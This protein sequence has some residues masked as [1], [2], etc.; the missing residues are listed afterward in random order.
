MFNIFHYLKKTYLPIICAAGIFTS[1]AVT[2][3]QH[4][5]LPL[6]QAVPG[7]IVFLEIKSNASTLPKV[8][9]N[10]QPVLVYQNNNK[11]FA[12]V[13]VPL[14]TKPGIYKIKY[15]Y[16]HNVEYQDFKIAAGKYDI[17]KITIKNKNMVNPDKKTLLI[18]AA[19]Q[20]KIQNALNS[21][22]AVAPQTLI[23]QQPV[24]GMLST[25]FGA[26]RIINGQIKNP[27]SGMDIAAPTGEAV[28]SAGEGVVT[29]ADNFYFS[30]NMVGIDHGSGLITLYAHLSKILVKVGDKVTTS[31][32]IG[33]VGS[34]GRV[35]G[36]HLHW[37]V[38]LN[39]ASVNPAL[40]ITAG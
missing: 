26:Q 7:G 16:D 35:T 36:P 37:T 4:L 21:T 19:D 20:A 30:G 33:K 40:F 6:E 22:R 15:E 31:D 13:G 1:S 32:M 24:K 29:L 2:G 25:S 3:V 12:M 8:Y 23:F 17:S 28:Y 5:Q 38:K 9:F 39:Q 34:T 18:I 14:N 11:S 27:H 10:D